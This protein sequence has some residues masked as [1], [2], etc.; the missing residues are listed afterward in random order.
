MAG[1]LKSSSRRNKK[2]FE[3]RI[4]LL[5]YFQYRAD[6]WTFKFL[7]QVKKKKTSTKTQG[8]IYLQNT[9]AV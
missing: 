4:T 5:F 6:Y 7:V 9:I 2:L 8:Y 1:K 3:L